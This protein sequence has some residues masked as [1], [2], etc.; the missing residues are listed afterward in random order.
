MDSIAKNRKARARRRWL[1]KNL[2]PEQVAKAAKAAKVGAQIAGVVGSFIP[3][4]GGVVNAAARG[5]EAAADRVEAG[6]NAVA[7]ATAKHRKRRAKNKAKV[8]A[9]KAGIRPQVFDK[10]RKAAAGDG[11]DLAAEVEAE[12]PARAPSSGGNGGKLLLG[13]LLLGGI[14][15]AVSRRRG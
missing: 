15:Y 1:K 13:A 5:V 3:G 2:T 12:L 11:V 14:G 7:G 8:A 6:A 4:V 9:V 10:A